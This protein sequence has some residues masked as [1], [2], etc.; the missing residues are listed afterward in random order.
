MII[1][2]IGFGKV[3]QNLKR[4]IQSEDIE[5]ITSLEG[6]SSKTIEMIKKMVNQQLSNQFN[7]ELSDLEENQIKINKT[8]INKPK[9]NMS[10]IERHI[11]NEFKEEDLELQTET[12]KVNILIEEHKNN[13]SKKQ[14]FKQLHSIYREYGL[15]PWKNKEYC[16]MVLIC[17]HPVNQTL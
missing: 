12:A 17:E 14:D 9:I 7:K 10:E 3:S 11:E 8:K 2:F 16:S 5:F 6:R 15:R 1:G 13:L 4:L